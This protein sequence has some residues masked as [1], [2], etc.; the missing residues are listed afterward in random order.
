MA[1]ISLWLQKELLVDQH[2]KQKL[3][4]LILLVIGQKVNT[5]VEIG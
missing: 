3:A 4:S 2:S 1:A 5:F